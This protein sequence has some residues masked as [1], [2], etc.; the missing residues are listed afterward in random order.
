MALPA[1][2]NVAIA[3]ALASLEREIQTARL[4]NDPLAQPL[5]ALAATV[6]AMHRL[7]SDGTLALK[8]AQQPSPIL[9]PDAERQLVERLAQEGWKAVKGATWEA[10]RQM[11]WRLAATV[12][13]SVAALVLVTGLACYSV[14][15]W[16]RGAA[17][18]APQS[19][20]TCREG[21][22]ISSADGSRKG[23]VVWLGPA[24][25]QP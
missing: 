4:T 13:T 15:W 19:L 6:Y 21:E 22:L 3:E 20:Q 24:P 23:C 17:D 10:H 9:T 18:A 8:E 7:F 12:G 16:H 2:T 1:A 5:K 11:N 25:Q 14:G